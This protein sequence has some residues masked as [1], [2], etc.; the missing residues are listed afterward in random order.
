MKIY[1]AGSIRAGRDNVEHYN[2]IIT[3]L[4]TY[5]EVL[6]EHIGDKTLSSGNINGNSRRKQSL[7]PIFRQG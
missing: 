4:K 2:K 3:F 1:F 5:G 7:R 6:T